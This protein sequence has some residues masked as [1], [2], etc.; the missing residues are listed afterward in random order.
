M[1]PRPVALVTGAG[2]EMGSLL[3]PALAARGHAIVALDLAELPA[4]LGEHCVEAL[5]LDLLDTPRLQSVFERVQPTHVFHLAA[6]LSSRAERDPRRAFRV[7][8]EATLELLR[9]CQLLSGG[10][11]RFIFPSSIA[12]YGLP[13]RATKNAHPELAEWQWTCPIG[14]YGIHKLYCELEGTYLSRRPTVEGGHRVD[15]RAIRF[16]GLISAETLPSGG[17]TDF[18]PE[19]IHAAARDEAYTCFVSAET[20]LPFMTMPD[21]VAA[22]LA[23]TEAEEA[24]LTRR[25]YNIQGFSSSAEEILDEARRC[26][27]RVRVRFESQPS[28]QAIVDSW[29]AGLDDQPARRDWGLSPRHGL[30]QALEEYLVPALERRYAVHAPSREEPSAGLPPPTTGAPR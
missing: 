7:N 3:L 5:Q 1:S 8:V 22:L 6:V 25:A 24:R 11:A 23:L 10:P 18:A 14:Q 12:V 20:R 16:P 17:T 21:A 15:F 13:D 26:F 27:P 28:R 19:M 2:G 29:P 4:T 30:R 9:L